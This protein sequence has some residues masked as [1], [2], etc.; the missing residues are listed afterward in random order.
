MENIIME[1]IIDLLS[2]IAAIAAVVISFF[3]YLINKNKSERYAQELDK[4]KESVDINRN[5]LIN[6]AHDVLHK[7]TMDINYQFL[8][9]DVDFP[10][11][12]NIQLPE[13][14]EEVKLTKKKTVLLLH[15]INL[16]Y[17]SF[18]YKDAVGPQVA[19]AYKNWMRVTVKPWIKS[20][21]VLRKVVI[22]FFAGKD[23]FQSEFIELLKEVLD[24]IDG[25]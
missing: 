1:N 19:N 6:S 4:I 23:L 20:D 8:E 12:L 9:K 24:D 2:L 10:V 5:L 25:N 22:N 15:Q 21:P 17:L 16:F 14:L 18:L 7:T 13:D 3:V 11:H